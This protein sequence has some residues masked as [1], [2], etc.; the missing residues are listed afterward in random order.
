[1]RSQILSCLIVACTILAAGPARSQTDKP[2]VWKFAH[3]SPIPGTVWQ[4][5]ATEVLPARVQQAT[6]G[7]VRVEVVSGVIQPS[8]VLAAIRDGQVQ[9]GSLT[10]PYVAA[11]LPTWGVL[12][13]PG[14]LTDESKYPQVINQVV[15]P[16]I[17]DE[18]RKRFK[19]EPVTVGAWAGMYFFSNGPVDSVDKFKG[20]KY[21]LASPELVQL[22][23]AVGGSPI[24]M[25]FGE[26][27]TSLQRG[28]VHAYNSALGS[29]RAAKLYE[30]TKYAENWPSGLG[31][32]AFFI[33]T[34]ALQKLS[35]ELRKKVF[36][37][38]V[39]VNHEAQ[40]AALVEAAAGRQ[41]LQAQGMTFIDVP[42]SERQKVI[43]VAKAQVW[44]KWLAST[45][46]T[47]KQLVQR[48]QAAAK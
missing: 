38:F 3:T 6:G 17:G 37:E 13:L 34:D 46:E 21:R 32:W 30:V 10:I 39:K 41:E 35:P 26:L 7:A 5:Y 11:T 27:Y 36:D 9:G 48:V 12:G 25:P 18:S 15:M 23:G 4:K 31:I 47:G 29:V 45:G 40:Q 33:G 8:D 1:M 24:G 22:I 42:E 19:A 14:L 16:M 28:M 44:P 2:V 20:V 43:A